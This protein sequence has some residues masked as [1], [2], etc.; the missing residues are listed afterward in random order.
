MPGTPTA[1]IAMAATAAAE[2][3]PDRRTTAAANRDSDSAAAP[4]TSTRRRIG[5]RAN[6][7]GTTR[8]RITSV[9]I[10]PQA[11]WKPNTR[12]GSSSLTTSDISPS[13]VVPAERL[14]GS[15]P[16]AIARIAAPRPGPRRYS[17]TR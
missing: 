7:P 2:I 3:R 9:A 8:N 14:H 17:S 6:T 10:T 5:Q 13:A 15:Q 12:I 16:T 11:A 1:A 4:S